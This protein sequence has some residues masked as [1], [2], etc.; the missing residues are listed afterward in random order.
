MSAKYPPKIVLTDLVEDYPPE[1]LEALN[2]SGISFVDAEAAGGDPWERISN[3]EVL[4]VAWYNV[5]AEVIQRLHR[6]KVIIRIGVG[7]D[8][9][10]ALAASKRNIAV[11]NVPDYCKGEVADHAMALALSL[12]RS[13]P[14][15]ERSLRESVWKPALPQAMHSFEAMNFG[16]L[17]Y[18]RIGRLTIARARGF[19]FHLM[20]CDPYLADTVFP[21]DVTRLDLDELLPR[22]DIL[23]VHV[24][25][26]SETRHLLNS[27]RLALMKSTAIL[28]NTARG[29]IVDSAALVD[30][31]ES[32]RL[33]AAGIDVFE[34]EPLPPEH[35]LLSC[36][37]VLITPHFAWY[38]RESRP[39]LYLMAVEEAIRG[40]CGEPLRSCVNCVQPGR[41]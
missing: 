3:A 16:V 17:G 26:T 9:I 23:S 39:R 11:C 6:C 19:G 15:L 27:D 31:L 32:G 1:A 13:L 40:V 36:P 22:V 18:G 25:L 20:A 35:P 12:A 4:I 28:V 21:D 8:N 30:A 24:P 2:A 38:S 5:S 33:A 37:N 10:D 41:V 29:P 14:F 34:E 7:Y